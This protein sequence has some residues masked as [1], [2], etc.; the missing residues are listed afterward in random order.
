M[1]QKQQG[2]AIHEQLIFHKNDINTTRRSS[3]FDD[4]P[5]TPSSNLELQSAGFSEVQEQGSGNSCNCCSSDSYQ[6]NQRLML[7]QKQQ[8]SLRMGHKNTEGGRQEAA[9]T[10]PLPP[11][12]IHPMLQLVNSRGARGANISNAIDPQCREQ[13][14]PQPGVK[15]KIG[16]GSG[17]T[18]FSSLNIESQVCQSVVLYYTKT[19]MFILV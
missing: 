9:T 13:Q 2:S 16:I 1:W 3:A 11:H 8:R 12:P 6:Q 18:L 19:L 17:D 14:V 7:S 10:T 5:R 4:Q 15:V